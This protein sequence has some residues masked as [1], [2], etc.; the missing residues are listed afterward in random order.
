[1]DDILQ[2]MKTPKSELE[3]RVS[4]LQKEMLGANLDAV[5]ILQQADKFYFSGTVQNG[6]IFIPIDGQPVFM[7]RKSLERAF[8]ES[9][10]DNIVPFKS[11][12]QMPEILKNH[13]LENFSRIGLE[14]DVMPV[15]IFKKLQNVFSG[16][17]ISDASP[18]IKKPT[19]VAGLKHIDRPGAARRSISER[20]E[21]IRRL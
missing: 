8:E 3:S 18:L 12:S 1:M 19:V 15:S 7:V 16:V 2:H 10:L 14:M 21:P 6:I 9:E 13:G 11:Y 20:R 17:K 5:L 4:R